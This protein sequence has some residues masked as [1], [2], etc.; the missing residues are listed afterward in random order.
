MEV[1]GKDEIASS[2]TATT[3]T[4]TGKQSKAYSPQFPLDQRR[5]K[6]MRAK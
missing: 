2:P 1:R 6:L 4:K 3:R 5:H